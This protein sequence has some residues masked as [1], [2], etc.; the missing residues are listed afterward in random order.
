MVLL[1][2]DG[3]LVFRGEELVGALLA[4]S[5]SGASASPSLPGGSPSAT[6]AVGQ[7]IDRA[8]EV[9]G[10]AVWT[11]AALADDGI[12]Y[13][14][15]PVG[16]LAR[17][18]RGFPRFLLGAPHWERALLAEWLLDPDVA[19]V[20]VT[21]ALHVTRLEGQ[22]QRQQ[23]QACTEA[24]AYNVELAGA[25][26]GEVW[27]VGRIGNVDAALVPT[28]GA[29]QGQHGYE[30][31]P[32][33]DADRPD[34]AWLSV[35]RRGQLHAEG[36]GG[37]G[38]GSRFPR[39]SL[40]LVP[41]GPADLAMLLPLVPRACQGEAPPGSPLPGV[42][43]ARRPS[44]MRH[45]AFVTDDAATL[46]ALNEACPGAALLQT[47]PGPSGDG[48]KPTADRLRAANV[49]VAIFAP[50]AAVGMWTAGFA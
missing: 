35:V 30:M 40:V 45:F 26:Y 19:T 36:E 48:W 47:E 5:S 43:F 31:E 16:Q 49:A 20:D 23:Q 27:G 9:G 10:R 44:M 21:T 13:F 12:D 18:G 42:A 41:A 22:Q 24:E 2:K 38:S 14:I 28:T 37:S 34:G 6:V 29:A 32:L 17:G 25:H 4:L 7:R 39:R 11:T 3:R 15:G 1:P 8:L 46:A 50:A 33:T